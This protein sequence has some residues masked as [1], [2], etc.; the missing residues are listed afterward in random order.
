MENAKTFAE[1]VDSK[2]AT[3]YDLDDSKKKV[4]HLLNKDC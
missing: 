1:L 3:H 4:R 2:L